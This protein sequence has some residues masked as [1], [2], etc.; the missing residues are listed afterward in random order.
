MIKTSS[1]RCARVRQGD[2]IRDVEFLEVVRESGGI[3]EISFVH[4]PVVVVLT[5][6]CDL[7]QDF[8]RRQNR[9]K[10]QGSRLVSALVAPLYN[11]AHVF[12]G[13]H[14]SELNLRADGISKKVEG[15]FIVQNRQPRYHYLEFPPSLGIADGIVDF[16][17]YFS[18]E[19]QGLARA[20]A[21]GFICRLDDLFREDLSHR[22]SSFL[23]RIGLPVIG[24]TG[25][26]GVASG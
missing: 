24:V 8:E 23:A 6:E 2:V 21:K 15:R 16:K 9:E 19:L 3:L 22:F 5:Q 20:K 1:E 10:P 14:L 17:H 13:S 26:A 25:D 18:V 12:E 7:E 4:Y 11:A